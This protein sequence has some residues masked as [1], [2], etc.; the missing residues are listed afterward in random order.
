MRRPATV[1]RALPLATLL[2]LLV[3]TLIHAAGGPAATDASSP[4]GLA[5]AQL[6]APV[7][8]EPTDT[9]RVASDDW[10][11]MPSVAPASRP[12]PELASE[13]RLFLRS[14]RPVQCLPCPPFHCCCGA[15][16]CCPD[17]SSQCNTTAALRF[18]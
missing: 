13:D 5:T 14:P 18:R 3:P 12:V 8:D 7:A 1:S 10:L 4:A 6:P 2:W 17:D 15:G 11:P 9:A 16:S